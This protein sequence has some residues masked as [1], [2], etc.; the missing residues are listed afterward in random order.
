MYK[1]VIALFAYGACVW[2]Q[3]PTKVDFARDVQPLFK[4]HCIG[5]HG[6]TQQRNGFRLDRRRD[7]M[8]GG[9]IAQIGPSNSA[10]SRLYLRLTGTQSGMQMPPTG[11]LAAAQIDI[12]KR[13]IDQGADWPDAL[14]GDVPAPPPDPAAVKLMTALRTTGKAPADLTGVNRKGVHGSTPL[15]YAVLYSDAATVRL[16]LEKGADPNIH[17]DAGATALMWAAGDLEKAKLLIGHGADVNAHSDGGRTPLLIAAGLGGPPAV[18][19][20]L[21][22]QG[23]NTNAR[24]PDLFGE[25]TPLAE[26]ASAGNDAAVRML[27][28]HGAD[29]KAA[30]FL[31]LFF[32]LTTHCEKCSEV[33]FKSAGPDVVNPVMALLAPPLGDGSA[34]PILLQHGAS[35]KGTDMGGNPI[36]TAVAGSEKLPVEF[37]SALLRSGA[38]VNA[39]NPDG[40]TALDIASRHGHTVMVDALLKAGAKESAAQPSE[41]QPKPA[42]SPRIALARTL[43]LLTRTDAAFLQKSGCVSC[44]NNTLTALTFAAARKYSIAVDEAAAHA[45]TKAIAN[46]IDGW[47]ERALQGVGIP[48]DADTVG[49]ILTALAASGHEPDESTDALAIFVKN[50][51]LPNGQWPLSGHRP[52]LESSAFS[53]TITAMRALQ[54]YAP[55]AQRA[56][57]N[58]AVQ[59]AAA[60]LATAR[61]ETTEDRACQL[62]GLGWAGSDK[63]VIRKTAAELLAQQRADGGWA[64][65]PTLSSD[66]FATGQVLV[67][68]HDSGAVAVTDPAY[69]RAVKFLLNSQ[70]EDGSWYVRRRALPLQ[71]YFESGFPYGHDQWISAAATNWAAMALAPLQ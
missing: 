23:A 8:R 31:P 57:Y 63:A 15:M 5:C 58:K 47:R 16:F 7:A 13:W 22:D 55:K 14:S 17:N 20:L 1:N 9:T 39:R 26:A 66:A 42:A 46:Y 65:I 35:A 71:P 60:W 68:L 40:E 30:G 67:G 19:K 38:D 28:E 70:A 59:R 61:P 29:V 64:Q 37:V 32:S 54:V 3:T 56:D 6:P 24:S 12:V 33:F 69:Q 45:Q 10:A 51:Q 49:P 53:S 25:M 62:I 11:P 36:L 2:A 18:V 52:P 50:R 34:A 44:H 43:P 4:E 48:G 41:F 27:L 21:L